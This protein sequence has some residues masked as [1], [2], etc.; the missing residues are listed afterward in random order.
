MIGGD[1]TEV[2]GLHLRQYKQN[3]RVKGATSIYLGISNQSVKSCLN[4]G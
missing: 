3:Y 1:N 4:P 2:L